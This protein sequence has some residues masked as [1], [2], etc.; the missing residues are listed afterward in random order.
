ME[1]AYRIALAL[2][3]AGGMTAL[4]TGL[5]A[6]IAEKGK[7]LHRISGKLYFWGMLLTCASA[8]Y[9]SITK[10]NLFLLHIGL[11]SLYMVYSGFRS[12][13]NKALHPSLLDWLMLIMAAVNGLFM[14]YSL[15]IILMVFGG[16]GT[17]LAF[18]DLKIFINLI[19]SQS[20]AKHIWLTRHIGAMLGSY[21]ATS[22]A[23]IVVNIQMTDYPWIPWLA[24][25]VIGTPLIAYWT[26][27]YTPKPGKK[28]QVLPIILI[29]IGLAPA[30]SFAQ[31]YIEGGHT[32]HRFAQL[33]LGID[34]R[35]F[36][37]HQTATSFVNASGLVEKKKLDH[38]T[39]TRLIIGG[40]HFWGHADFYIAIPV[41]K[42]PNTGF[43]TGVE[44][45]ALYYP[46]AIQ[47]HKLRPYIGAAFVPYRYQQG[48]GT[49]LTRFKWPLTAGVTFNHHHHL[50]QLSCGYNTDAQEKYYI[51]PETAVAVKTSPLWFSLGYKYMLETTVSAEK[52]WLSGRTKLLTDT[53]AALHRLNGLT[54]GIGPSS[55]FFL[56]QSSYLNDVAPAADQHRVVD[57]FM[58]YALG[59]YWHRPDLQANLSFRKIQSTLKAY[60]FEQTATRQALTVELYKFISDYHGFAAFVGPAM[61]YEMLALDQAKS[62]VWKP[63]LTFGW[64]IRPNR[65]QSWYLRTN[66]RY[67]PNMHIKTQQGQTFHFDQL[68]F[69]FIQLVIFPGRMF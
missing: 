10:Q 31:T 16:I 3:I 9:I 42:Q 21:I 4:V 13:Q 7:R 39:E 22:T 18:N 64:D 34:Q 41:I 54:V 56:K 35:F 14:I 65:I 47:H 58:E 61:S 40:T 46:W 43:H 38:F 63:G 49:E 57:V 69:N 45:G 52:D 60:D 23:F 24:P 66:L 62:K 53:L 67:F 50:I 27:R 2:H 59:Y 28:T 30:R 37:N 8:L 25:T 33:N 5:F 20:I 29:I 51:T 48:E 36:P 68:E 12:I 6:I 17:W 55:A 32:R 11:F 19:K 26:K 1:T 15:K 44:T